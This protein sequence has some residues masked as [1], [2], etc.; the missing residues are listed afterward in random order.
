MAEH[1]T[2]PTDATTGTHEKKDTKDPM[3]Q[4]EAKAKGHANKQQRGHAQRKGKGAQT[5]S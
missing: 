4:D 2:R 1:K 5:A 3:Y